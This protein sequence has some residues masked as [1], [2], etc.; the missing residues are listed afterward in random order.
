MSGALLQAL[1][2][3]AGGLPRTYWVLWMGTLVNRL[4]AFVVPF[5]ALYLTR[6]RGYTV[7]HAGLIVSLH[8]AGVVL[9][10]PLG[11][12]LADRI[13]RRLTL[14]GGLW[15]GSVGMLFL[16]FSREP[17]WIAVA[18]F[19]LGVLGDLYRPAVSAAVADVV[20]PGDRTRAFGLLYWVINLGVAI[21]VP[22]AGWLTHFGYT[23]LFVADAITTFAYG[24]CIWLLL[25]ETRPAGPARSTTT[26]PR[27]PLGELLAPYRDPV[28]LAFGLP[29]F[30]VA[31]IFLQCHV[32]LPMDLGQRGLTPAQYGTV[33]AV[34]GVLIVVL[35]PFT[36]RMLGGMRRA[37]A[38]ALAAALTGLGF[39]M[40]ALSTSVPLAMLAVAVWTVGE[41]LQAPVAPSVV[42]DLAPP[43]LRGGYQGA[44]YMM[45]GLAS[46]AAPAL[47]GQ[48]LG[49][50]GPTTLWLGCLVLGCAAGLW[51]LAIAGARRR[52]LDALR[53]VRPELS[54][55]AD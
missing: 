44:Y 11:G 37:V 20:P 26:S 23:L 25:P 55:S 14:A 22:L 7:E 38:L 31:L 12:T 8:G 24:C 52:R 27:A 15:L 21:A 45:W 1:R 47:G 50:F 54:A 4:G 48:V 16:G 18:A 30:V 3:Q 40:H 19:T 41:I 2:A 46:C 36:G 35:Q 29:I 39:G 5:L 9:A 51:H 43:E 28:F 34:N 42:A 10:G 49:R 33:L 13:G 32:A 53:T 6:E 17:F